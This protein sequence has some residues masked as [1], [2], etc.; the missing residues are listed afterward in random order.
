MGEKYVPEIGQ[1][2]LGNEW[3]EYELPTHADLMW[4][5]VMEEIYRV[6]WNRNQEQWDGRYD[7]E[8]PGVTWRAYCWDDE[9]PEADKPNLEFKDVHICW[10][11]Y[12]GRG[13]SVN[14]EMSAEEWCQWMSDLFAVIRAAD[15]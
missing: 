12:P 1:A 6:Y 5:G 13:M 11:K 10:Y 3:G 7:P 15:T 14:K 8:I 9:S 4:S 2:V